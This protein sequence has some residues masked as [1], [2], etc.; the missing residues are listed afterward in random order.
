MQYAGAAAKLPD[1]GGIAG[2]T[3]AK[4]ARCTQAGGRDEGRLAR[5]N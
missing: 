5:G 4:T 2:P 1:G 3:L